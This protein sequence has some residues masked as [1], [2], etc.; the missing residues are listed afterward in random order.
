[1][2]ARSV[3]IQLGKSMRVSRDGLEASPSLRDIRV[4][5]SN[6]TSRDLEALI[7]ELDAKK[8]DVSTRAVAEGVA[9]LGASALVPTSQ[10]G[11]GTADATTFLR[12]DQTWAV[13]GGSGA[14]ATTVEVNL[15]ATATW[16]GKFTI[17]DA[18]IAGT[19]KV[20]C[21]QAPGPYTGKGT[22]ADEA[23]AQP[24]HVISVEPA[25]GSATVYWQ[26]P[27]GFVSR[28]IVP[29]GNRDAPLT[30]SGFDP[31]YPYVASEAIR[32]G[33]VRGNVK[34]SYMVLA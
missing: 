3:S 31:R 19:S 8:I 5:L 1:M 7:E 28:P 18:A 4:A 17:V 34:F 22:R 25:A 21:W 23:E 20:L 30:A 27:P 33:R 2:T 10:L 32:K 16:R 26:T 29:S 13:P 9:T 15:G 14:T 11:T 6:F 12:G 24:V